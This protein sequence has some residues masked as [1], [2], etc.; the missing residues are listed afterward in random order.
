[1]FPPGPYVLVVD[2]DDDARE[3]AARTARKA[4]DRVV[5][6]ENGI[7]ALQRLQEHGT[8]AVIL[9]DLMMPE[10]D[11]FTFLREIRAREEFRAVPV[12]VITAK[13]LTRSEQAFLSGAARRVVQKGSGDAGHSFA[14]LADQIL[15]LVQL[16]PLDEK[17][18]AE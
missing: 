4:C 1:M 5:T 10:M 3:M 14:N 12:V 17:E 15:T 18:A 16:K 9:L 11:G 2:D 8:P 6:A 7:V 13:E